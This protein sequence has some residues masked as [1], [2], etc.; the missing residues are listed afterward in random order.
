MSRRKIAALAWRRA[1]F[2]S[3]PAC[4]GED[5]EAA[6][7]RR[8][9]AP[10]QKPGKKKGEKAPAGESGSGQGKKDGQGKKSKSRRRD[11]RRPMEPQ[12]PHTKD[13][14]E[15]NSLMKPFYLTRD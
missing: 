15:Q 3:L 10:E 11:G 6:Q 2:L 9:K 14:T 13:S 5:R 8:E 7:P 4:G 12:R 1:L